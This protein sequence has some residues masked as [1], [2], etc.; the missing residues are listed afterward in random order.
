MKAILELGFQSPPYVQIAVLTALEQI[1]DAQAIPLVENLAMSSS[2]QVR[3]RAKQCLPFL[4]ERSQRNELSLTLLRGTA[5]P[6]ME[7]TGKELLRP[8]VEET[9]AENLLRPSD[10]S[11]SD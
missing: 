10:Q 3:E 2:P 8:A 11:P 1:G 6:S 7:A 5:N 9:S 4:R